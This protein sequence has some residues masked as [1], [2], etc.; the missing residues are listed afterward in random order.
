VTALE[1]PG[2][3]FEVRSEGGKLQAAS[4]LPRAVSEALRGLRK[5][6]RWRGI[7]VRADYGAI[8]ITRTS[9]ASRGWLYDLWLAERIAG[10]PGN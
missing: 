10:S 6:K 8:V 4:N 1:A 9:D 5:A 2:P 7:E 3:A